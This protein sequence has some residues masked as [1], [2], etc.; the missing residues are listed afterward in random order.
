MVEPTGTLRLYETD[1]DE[2]DEKEPLQETTQEIDSYVKP[3][4]GVLAG[5]FRTDNLPGITATDGSTYSI[6]NGTKTKNS[7]VVSCQSNNTSRGIVI[8]TDSTEETIND[9]SL[10]NKQTAS[11]DYGGT[12]VSGPSVNAPDASLDVTRTF[13]NNRDDTVTIREVGIVSR[14]D[15][16]SGGKNFLLLRDTGSPLLTVGAGNNATV[17]YTLT[18]TV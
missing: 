11:V 18:V 13:T 9:T 10:G 6:K 17:E 3:F 5:Q 16:N 2:P 12:T 15:T 1:P 14:T 7:M 8:G 4:I